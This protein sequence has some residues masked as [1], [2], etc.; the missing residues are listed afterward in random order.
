[1]Q[2]GAAPTVSEAVDVAL[3][4]V[5]T[6]AESLGLMP[7]DVDELLVPTL[8]GYV[9]KTN[10]SWQRTCRQL[11]MAFTDGSEYTAFLSFT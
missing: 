3:N 2:A 4:Y 6:N 8:T 9:W 7:G 1:V 11:T 5:R 10:G